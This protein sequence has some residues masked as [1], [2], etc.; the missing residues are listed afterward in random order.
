LEKGLTD[1]NIAQ[2]DY[3]SIYQ[4]DLQHALM[5]CVKELSAKN[6]ELIARLSAPEA[7]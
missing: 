4:T 3:L 1:D 5:K 7:K 6:D 2:L